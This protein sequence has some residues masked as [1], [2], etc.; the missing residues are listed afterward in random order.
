MP[1][2]D[3][4]SPSFNTRKYVH[5]DLE[6]PNLGRQHMK[7]EVEKRLLGCACIFTPGI[8]Y[9]SIKLKLNQ[10]KTPSREAIFLGLS[11]R[12]ALHIGML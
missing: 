6:L 12:T 10:G 7:F 2:I 4:I 5:N 11:W 8:P 3:L 1:R 9:R